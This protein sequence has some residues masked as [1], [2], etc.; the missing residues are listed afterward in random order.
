MSKKLFERNEG[1]LV[2]LISLSV[3]LL[4]A[5][6]I[7]SFIDLGRENWYWIIPLAI[8][9]FIIYKI[10]EVVISLLFKNRNIKVSEGYFI[11]VIVIIALINTFIIY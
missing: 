6:I 5:S 9:V 11:L 8:L 1:N 3:G 10:L 2:G 4:A 7:A